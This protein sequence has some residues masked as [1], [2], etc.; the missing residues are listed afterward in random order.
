MAATELAL[1]D[2]VRLGLP[3]RLIGL[4]D[5]ALAVVLASVSEPRQ[6][7][8]DEALGDSVHLRLRAEAALSDHGR[9]SALHEAKDYLATTPH[10]GVLGPHRESPNFL[11]LTSREHLPRVD[12]FRLNQGGTPSTGVFADTT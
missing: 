12:D 10:S 1:E 6:S 4:G 2:D 9:G 5:L 8:R 11:P 3:V 7:M